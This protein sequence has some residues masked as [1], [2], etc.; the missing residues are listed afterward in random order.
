M[1]H[2]L[3]RGGTGSNGCAVIISPV[4]IKG[5]LDPVLDT[6]CNDT[7]RRG[8]SFLVSGLSAGIT[9]SLFALHSR[10]RTVNTGNSHCF[11]GRNIT[12]RP[13]AIFS[14]NILGAC[15]VSACGNGGVSVTPA[16]DT[17][18]HLVL[19]PNSG[20]LGKLITSVGRN[21]LIANFGNNGDGDD[22]NSFSCNVRNFLVRSNGLARPIGRVGIA[23]GVIAL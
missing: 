17:P 8:G 3:K 4:G 6:L 18:S 22:A 5:L 11:S 10:P 23:N 19:A 2:G 9:S 21:V 1:L 15:F 16:V 14:G 12:A 7:L 13:H 20:S